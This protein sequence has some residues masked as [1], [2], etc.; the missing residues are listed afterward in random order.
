[1]AILHCEATLE[2]FKIQQE[3]EGNFFVLQFKTKDLT[4]EQVKTFV[5]AVCI[6]D[7]EQQD[8]FEQP[9]TWRPSVC[10]DYWAS[11]SKLEFDT[12][13]AINAEFE[14]REFNASCRK[15]AVLPQVGGYYQIKLQ[16]WKNPE[17]EGDMELAFF[18]QE[19]E[20][21]AASG[22]IMKVARSLQIKACDM[23]GAN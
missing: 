13:K 7:T 1:M 16:L 10:L 4:Q 11:W 8:M 17:R 9:S 21:D 2:G 6:K 19:K 23:P 3:K 22:K 18:V 12:H 20:E 14:D 5:D 15:V